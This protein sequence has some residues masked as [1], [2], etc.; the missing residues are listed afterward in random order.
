MQYK[1][2][3][4]P[5][6]YAYEVA[7]QANIKIL[8][9][10]LQGDWLPNTPERLYLP[11]SSGLQRPITL[12]SIEDQIVLQAIANQF[13][14]TLYDRR[15]NVEKKVVFSNL[16]THPRDSKFFIQ[17]WHETYNLFQTI[18]VKYFNNGYRWVAHFDLSAFYDTISHEELIKRIS[19]RGG[20]RDASDKI[21]QWLRAWC[22]VDV[23]RSI[24]HGI[25]QGPIASDLLAECFLLPLDEAL[26]EDNIRY[27]RYVDDIRT[28]SKSRFEAQKTAIKLE[29]YC[30]ELGLIP[31]GKKFS[32]GEAKAPSQVLGI[33]PSLAPPDRVE[34]VQ[35]KII[36]AKDAEQKFR[37]S[38]SGRPYEIVDRSLA[39]YVLYRAPKS[40]KLLNWVLLLLPRHPE[41]I[42]AFTHY[43][44]NYSRS[45][46]AERT[47][48]EMLENG[49][50]YEY[51]RGELWHVLA[52]IASKQNLEKMIPYA[53]K[54][55][56]KNNTS[57]VQ[58]WGALSFLIFCQKN[59]LGLFA[60]RIK[61]KSPLLQ[62]LV[63][64]IIPDIEYERKKLIA[65]LLRSTNY[66]PGIMLA[67]QLIQRNISH[68]D[69]G[70]APTDLPVQVQNVFQNLGIIPQQT[71]QRIDQV[72]EILHRRFGIVNIPRWRN[73]LEQEYVYTLQLL[74]Q[75]EA[76]FDA[77]RSQWLLFQNSFN[78]ALLRQF[79][80]FLGNHRL[81]GTMILVGRNN[82]LI[83]FGVLLD[84]KQRFSRNYPVIANGFR[85]ANNRR[86]TLPGS[87]PYE[88]KG[89][90]QNKHLGLNDRNR[91][92]GLLSQSYNQLI[93]IVDTNS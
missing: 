39:R 27:V 28:F 12:L 93:E 57:L 48:C 53:K 18:C 92:K 25:P 29:V 73:V 26:M 46:P 84:T 11:K 7:Y 83:K 89:G 68:T 66:E 40:K 38:I 35:P 6:Y 31:Q 75:A 8:R 19:P 77:G 22:S 33:M 76:I 88:E 47:I 81:P 13:A 4:R 21:R 86:N 60:H 82:K 54:D 74:L 9:Q 32:I 2:F 49:A 14:S 69:F 58:K 36:S 90:S 85:E 70:I 10:K 80:R 67:E 64:G 20:N 52:R 30:R 62:A 51:V 50:P 1:R 42:D 44:S 17:D 61:H 72:G 59:D 87:H 79:I 63:V 15:K 34:S 3:F 45:R 16:L 78:D 37:K 24:D 56:T 91:I 71:M 5:I 65:D 43:L 23:S 41:H 55:V